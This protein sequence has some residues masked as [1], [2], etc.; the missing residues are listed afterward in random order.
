MAKNRRPS[1]RPR[2]LRGSRRLGDWETF[3]GSTVPAAGGPPPVPASAAPPAWNTRVQI[4]LAGAGVSTPQ[5]YQIA[6]Q[7]PLA[8]GGTGISVGSAEI[9]EFD[10]EVDILDFQKLLTAPTAIPVTVGI[11][12]YWSSL[13]RQSA[14]S[15]VWST[16]DPLNPNDLTRDDWIARRAHAF[17]LADFPTVQ[18]TDEFS[19]AAWRVP[20]LSF[21]V[22]RP[23][24]FGQGKCLSCV[25]SVL[26][27]INGV[28]QIVDFAVRTRVR[29]SQ[30]W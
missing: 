23:L 4:N 24:R 11:G 13:S 28:G 14:T 5:S 25:L 9:A 18:N 15:V 27:F 3:D 29:Y 2:L 22:R 19:S 7:N 10:F 16:R 21:H 12:L 8:Q 30:V 6:A 26:P 20:N 1:R 17:W